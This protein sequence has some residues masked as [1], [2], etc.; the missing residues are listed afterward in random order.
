MANR[1]RNA[2]FAHFASIGEAPHKEMGQVPVPCPKVQVT[3]ANNGITTMQYDN[4]GQ[5]VFSTDPEG[6]TTH[7]GYDNLGRLIYRHHPDAGTTQ[8]EYD[9]AGNITK[10]TNPLG[11]IFYDYEYYRPIYKRYSY[12]TGND[13]TYEYDTNGNGRGRLW[14][15]TDGSG[16]CEYKYDK[17][18]NVAMSLTKFEPSPCHIAT[19]KSTASTWTT[20]MTAGDVC[21]K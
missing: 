2:R 18:G 10:E 21:T 12:M 14:R 9:P 11:E 16:M 8:Y 6:F 17:L 15:I 20:P 13:V 4:L 1:T 5:L 3:D 7:Y 19:V